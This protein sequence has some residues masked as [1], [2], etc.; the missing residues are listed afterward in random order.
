VAPSDATG[1]VQ[2]K[3]KFQDKIT[4]LGEVSVRTGGLAVLITKKLTKGVHSLTAMFTPRDPV[5]FKP[6]TSNTMTV[7]VGG[8]W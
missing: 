6:S 2:F 4:T 8:D 7:E 3:D 1:T 5:A